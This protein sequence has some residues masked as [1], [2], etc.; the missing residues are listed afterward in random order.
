MKISQLDKVLKLF[1][2]VVNSFF[3]LAEGFPS[4]LDV[5]DLAMSYLHLIFSNVMPSFL[6]VLVRFL[7]N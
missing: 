4:S 6:P 2:T 1:I 5:K 7:S 3:R